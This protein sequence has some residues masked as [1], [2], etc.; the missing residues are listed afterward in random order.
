MN[1]VLGLVTGL[2]ALV[3]LYFIFQQRRNERRKARLEAYPQRVEVFRCTEEFLGRAWTGNYDDMQVLLQRF[4]HCKRKAQFLFDK[5]LAA[6]LDSLHEGVEEH[7]LLEARLQI[8]G[9]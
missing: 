5:S 6:Y 4:F 1:E 3:G 9:K 2:V 7:F 8:E